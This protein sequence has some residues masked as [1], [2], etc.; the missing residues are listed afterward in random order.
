V[1]TKKESSVATTK[2]PTNHVNKSMLFLLSKYFKSLINEKLNKP[3]LVPFKKCLYLEI[4]KSSAFFS[5]FKK[6]YL[7]TRS[8]S[9]LQILAHKPLHYSTRPAR[10]ADIF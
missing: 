10:F 3:S 7:K 4:V 9:S 8:V 1:S 6:N 5:F 2:A